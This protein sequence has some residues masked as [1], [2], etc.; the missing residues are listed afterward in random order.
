MPIIVDNFVNNNSQF[1][2]CNKHPN[3]EL[4]VEP[5]Q[6]NHSIYTNYKYYY[7]RRS[8]A[9]VRDTLAFLGRRGDIEENLTSWIIRSMLNID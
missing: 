2:V 8:F 6:D 3:A 4:K 1:M 7:C 5:F 9:K